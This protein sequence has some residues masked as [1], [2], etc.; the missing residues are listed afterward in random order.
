MKIIFVEDMHCEKCVERISNIMK[1]EGI[2]AG[3][4]LGSKTVTVSDDD[5]VVGRALEALS[6]LGFEGVLQ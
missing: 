2:D 3:I 6:D 1:E 4:D 5:S